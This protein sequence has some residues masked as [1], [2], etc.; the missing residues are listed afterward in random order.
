MFTKLHHHRERE[1]EKGQGLVEY[2]LILV[3]V[4]IAVIAI[5]SV[6]GNSVGGVFTQVDAALNG[7][8]LSGEGTEYVVGGFSASSSGGPAVCSVSTSSFTVTM[9]EDGEPV[10]AGQTVSISA[11]ATGGSGT[12]ASASTN[13]SG[14]ASFSGV[15]MSGNC[16]GS[17]TVSAGDSSR[18]A[19]Y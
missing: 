1:E 15:N 10:G 4:S 14:Q 6:L 5:L 12:S 17:V 16:S 8:F 2:A 7:Q 3:L 19:S 11:S 13:D 9:Y 18:N